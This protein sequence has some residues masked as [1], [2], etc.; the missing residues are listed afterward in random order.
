M[1]VEVFK[2]FKKGDE[3]V[4]NAKAINQSIRNILTTMIG[5]MP[6]KPEFGSTI[7]ELIFEPL[8]HIVEDSIISSVYGALGRWEPRINVLDVSV[9]QVPEYNRAVVSI[10]Y[11]YNLSGEILSEL[12]KVSFNQG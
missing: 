12:T 1:A 7:H 2:D 11:E 3:Y 9:E 10:E 5:S 6:G 8:D 4:T